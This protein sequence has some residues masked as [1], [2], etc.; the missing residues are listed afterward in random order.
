MR[1]LGVVLV[2]LL[3]G[4]AASAASASTPGTNG[5]IMFTQP[6]CPGWASSR[7]PALPQPCVVDPVTRTSFV[8][9]LPLGAVLSPDG[10]RYAFGAYRDAV[11]QLLVADADGGSERAIA[12]TDGASGPWPSWSPDGSRVAFIG[13]APTNPPP[14]EVANPSAG[15]VDR[16]AS[17]AFQPSWSPDGTELAVVAF[18]PDVH[19]VIGAVDAQS[20]KTRL[21]TSE[22]GGATQPADS[23]PDWSPD[24]ARIAFTHLELGLPARL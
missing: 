16:L 13:T 10:R 9:A 19:Q 1:K 4:A 21:V 8:P 11:Y 5:A 18:D 15:R 23:E 17:P 6:R 3:A 14:L 22:P 12:P 2:A 7:C 24:A 20:G